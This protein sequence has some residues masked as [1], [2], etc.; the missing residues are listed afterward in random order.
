MAIASENAAIAGFLPPFGVAKAAGTGKAAGT[1]HSLWTIAG[2]PGAGAAAGSANGALVLDSTAGAFGFTNPT[3]PALSYL[4]TLQLSS[5]VQCAV[6]VYDRLW[7]NSALSGT[8]A[9]AQTITQP[10]ITRITNFAGVMPFVEIYAATGATQVNITLAYT[11]QSG[12]AGR[13]A[14]TAFLASP[15][16]GQALPLAL[17]SGDYGVQS[18]QS[19]TL[20]ATTATAGNF[21]LTLAKPLAMVPIQANLAT[22]LGIYDLGMP[23]IADD[24]AIAFMALLSS[25]TT[26]ALV[27]TWNMTQG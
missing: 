6:M 4:A 19:V 25:T 17:Q 5:P 1:W 16:A 2:L 27:G 13:S 26:P 24:A 22:T 21:G 20:S 10:A 18:V 8:V 7:H 11:N 15:V 14:V 3:A 12:T 23:Q 9:T